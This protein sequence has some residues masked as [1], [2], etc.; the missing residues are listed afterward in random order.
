MSV[1]DSLVL[2]LHPTQY[3]PL[4]VPYSWYSF[5][6]QNFVNH[7]PL[8]YKIVLLVTFSQKAI[9]TFYQVLSKLV[10]TRDAGNVKFSLVPRL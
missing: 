4:L 6:R 5:A 9:Y 7:D 3:I 2:S 10:Y 1:F 8:Y